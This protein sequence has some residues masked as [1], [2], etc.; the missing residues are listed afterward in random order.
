MNTAQNKIHH[1][2]TGGSPIPLAGRAM[3][4]LRAVVWIVLIIYWAWAAGAAW[5]FNVAPKF[6]RAVLAILIIAVP[7]I[8]SVRTRSFKFVSMAIFGVIAVMA[9]CWQ[10]LVPST[11]RNWKPELAKT[12]TATVADDRVEISN[13]MAYEG[14]ATQS[15]DLR[16]IKQVW[17]GV[18]K[19]AQFGGGAH[20]FLSFEF[21]DGKFVS[22]SV[23]ARKELDEEFALLPALFRQFEL[24]YLIGDEAQIFGA[25]ADFAA[26]MYL[27]PLRSSPDERVALFVD[28]CNRANELAGQPEWYNILSNN[29]TNNLAWH[30]SRIAPRPISSYDMRVV[31]SGHADRLLYDMGLLDVEGELMEIEERCRVD[32]VGKQLEIDSQFP[33]RIRKQHEE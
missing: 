26:P 11:E 4:F 33:L 13:Y 10:M 27:Y 22:V 16:E 21:N 29:C 9:L 14:P 25:R 5:H 12:P 8:V 17:F 23:E 20:N 32:E 1:P 28:M 18:E 31:I 15:F 7:L 24:I 3:F 2:A 30:A 6:L 19:F